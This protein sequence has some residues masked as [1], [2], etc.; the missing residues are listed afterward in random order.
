MS[1]A[2][3][4]VAEAPLAQAVS[5]VPVRKPPRKRQ[6]VAKPDRI[7]APEPR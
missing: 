4:A 7:A 6:Y 3:F 1:I 2:A 5:A